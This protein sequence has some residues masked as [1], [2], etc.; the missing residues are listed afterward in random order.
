MQESGRIKLLVTGGAQK[1]NERDR[2]C[3]P[4]RH[5]FLFPKLSGWYLSDLKERWRERYRERRE[6]ERERERDESV[7]RPTTVSMRQ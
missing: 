6:R 4:Q 1:K 7:H 5:Y 3:G 2:C